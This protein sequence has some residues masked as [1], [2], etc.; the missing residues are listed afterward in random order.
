MEE[1]GEGER[2]RP[3]PAADMIGCLEDQDR[4]AGAGQDDGGGEPVGAGADDDRVRRGCGGYDLSS[5]KA[6]SWFANVI[7]PE[8]AR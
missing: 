7:A 6:L 8:A 1:A 4:L 5:M 2:L 3:G